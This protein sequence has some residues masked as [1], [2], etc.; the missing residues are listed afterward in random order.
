MANPLVTQA[1]ITKYHG[2]TNTVGSRISAT[3]ASGIRVFIPYP[4]EANTEEAHRRAAD[5]LIAKLGWETDK[6]YAQG[7]LKTGYAF[8]AIG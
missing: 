6:P 7:A 5:K 2:P 3:S 4:H 8:V 1:I